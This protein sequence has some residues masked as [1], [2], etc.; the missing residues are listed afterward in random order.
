M[1]KF[2]STSPSSEP[3]PP[4]VETSFLARDKQEKLVDPSEVADKFQDLV[5]AGKDE[6]NPNYLALDY[7]M[8]L[9]AGH[10]DSNQASKENTKDYLTVEKILK[11]GV[12]KSLKIEPSALSILNERIADMTYLTYDS[13]QEAK[14]AGNY[15]QRRQLAKEISA[16]LAK[17]MQNIGDDEDFLRAVKSK[18]P[19]KQIH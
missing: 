9:V 17:A 13:K 14:G 8:N 15:K 11:D 4:G 18:K 1:N 6:N 10:K 2:F 3:N 16:I 12:L 5:S 7:E 19:E